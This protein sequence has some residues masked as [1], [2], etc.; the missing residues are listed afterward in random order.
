LVGFLVR[1]ADEMKI[2]QR[3]SAG[4]GVNQLNQSPRRGRQN[5]RTANDS[6]RVKG[7]TFEEFSTLFGLTLNLY[8]ARYR[9]RFCNSVVRFTDLRSLSSDPSAEALGYFHAVRYR[10]RAAKSFW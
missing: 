3:F 1:E 6:E 5:Y 7:A 4:S 10:G 8:P 9:S 2:A